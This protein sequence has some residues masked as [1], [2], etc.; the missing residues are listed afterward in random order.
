MEEKERRIPQAGR[1]VRFQTRV[2]RRAIK[3]SEAGGGGRGGGG[4]GGGG[5]RGIYGT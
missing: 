3:M 2:R 4:G 5:G 1:A